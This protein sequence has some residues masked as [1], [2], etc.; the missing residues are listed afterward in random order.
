MEL[1]FFSLRINCYTLTVIVQ[2][3]KI[4]TD[5]LRLKNFLILI[6]IQLYLL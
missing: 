5:F 2:I 6:K 1:S 4:Y 3:K